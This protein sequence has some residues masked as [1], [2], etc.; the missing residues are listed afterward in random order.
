VRAPDLQL[1]Q[2]HEVARVLAG[3]PAKLERLPKGGRNSRIYRVQC[4]AGEYALKQYPSRTGDPRDRLGTEVGALKLME[5]NGVTAI[6]RVVAVD[7]MHG[8]A[9][10]TWIDGVAITDIADFDIDAAADFLA[11][12]HALRIMPAAQE[13]PLAAEVCLSGLEIERQIAERFARLQRTTEPDL[14][15]FLDKAFAPALE[16]ESVK[17]RAKVQA[18]SLDFAGKLPQEWRSL[19][20][21]DFGFHNSLRRKDGSLA[22]VDFEYFGWGDPAK[23]TADILLHPG[24]ILKTPQRRR[25]R[26]RA[27]WLY[28]ADRSFATRLDAY[29]PLFGLRWVLILLNEFVPDR[30]Q[31][32]VSA[33]ATD[34]WAQA[35]AAQ[36]SHAIDFLAALPE[37]VES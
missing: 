28:G 20:A 26:Q 4:D 36:L 9:L 12:I 3:M 13:Q 8:F 14:L 11:E 25:F 16:R 33:G 10:L 32:R 1:A 35:K 5:H 22:F 30:W 21:S 18:A 15:L 31:R 29:L 34:S 7:E 2:A 24:K 27:K 17:A 6:P 37:K 19:V 23:L